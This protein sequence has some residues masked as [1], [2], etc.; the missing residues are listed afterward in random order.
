[1]SHDVD[2]PLRL[3]LQVDIFLIDDNAASS[4]RRILIQ[5]VRPAAAAQRERGRPRPQSNA[6]SCILYQ[7]QG[8]F[9]RRSIFLCF[10]LMLTPVSRFSRVAGNVCRLTVLSYVLL[11]RL[12]FVAW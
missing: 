8:P 10:V 6:Y 12:E 2:L 1:M 4:K 9:E 3:L 5:Q 11:N 7:T